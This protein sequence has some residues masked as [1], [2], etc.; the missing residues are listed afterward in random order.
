MYIFIHD[1]IAGYGN[2]VLLWRGYSPGRCH[3]FYQLIKNYRAQ[4]KELGHHLQRDKEN[5]AVKQDPHDAKHKFEVS[6]F[7]SQLLAD[8][9][10]LKWLL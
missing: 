1:Y 5:H 4:Q 9:H 10:V 2:H 8:V 6:C 3:L 7:P